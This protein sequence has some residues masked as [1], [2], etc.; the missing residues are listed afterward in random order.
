M[1]CPMPRTLDKITATFEQGGAVIVGTD[2]LDTLKQYLTVTATYSDSTTRVLD[3]SEYTLSG[4]LEYP[5]VSA[6]L[7]TCTTA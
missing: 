4:T 3:A 5:S 6:R 2:S 7:A 1:P